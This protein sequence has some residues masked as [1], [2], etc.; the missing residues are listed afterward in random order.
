MLKQMRN[1]ASQDTDSTSTKTFGALINASIFVL[2]V[3][4][5]TFLLV[6]L[7]KR[8]VGPSPRLACGCCACCWLIA[9]G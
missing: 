4:L 2:I 7:F 3:T 9:N 5:M 6:F 1:A 8:G